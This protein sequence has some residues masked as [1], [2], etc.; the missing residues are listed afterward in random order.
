MYLGIDQSLRSTGVA[1]VDAKGSVVYTGTVTPGKLTGVERLAYIRRGLQEALAVVEG[2]PVFHAAL[3][4]YSYGSTGSLCE[5]G[6]VGAVARLLLYDAGISFVV[7]AP[8]QLKQFVTG[9]G[10]AKK[11]DVRQAVLKK[12]GIDIDQD[13]ECDAFGLAQLAKS[14]HLNSGTT[15][16]ELEVLKKLRAPKRKNLRVV[17]AVYAGPSL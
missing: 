11:E 16:P 4:G 8:A 17:P 15:R 12:W 13:D 14:F 9:N 7:V 3:E 6:E 2:S 10:Q 5:L 1:L